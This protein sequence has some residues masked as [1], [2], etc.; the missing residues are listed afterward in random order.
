LLC[1]LRQLIIA[2]TSNTLLVITYMSKQATV[3]AK[4]PVELKM[5]LID[6]DVNIAKSF[7]KHCRLK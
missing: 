3:C 2:V 1:F 7:G 5:K 6:Y 4:I